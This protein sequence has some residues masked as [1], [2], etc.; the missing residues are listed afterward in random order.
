M[1]E[2][3][4]LKL[5]AQRDSAAA[6]MQQA[7]EDLTALDAAWPDHPEVAIV[8]AKQWLARMAEAWAGVRDWAAQAIRGDAERE[9][10]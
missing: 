6:R 10:L 2:A 7:R 8:E 3:D 5:E 9:L 1:K 4:L